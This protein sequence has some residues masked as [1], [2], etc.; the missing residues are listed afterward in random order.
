MAM[1]A[2][3]GSWIPASGARPARFA[4]WGEV[5]AGGAR[6]RARR[7]LMPAPQPHPFAA[8]PAQLQA[9]L[10]SLETPLDAVPETVH[11]LA[12][13]PSADGRPLPSPDLAP[14]VAASDDVAALVTWAVPALAPGPLH[15]AEVLLALPEEESSPSLAVGEDLRFW[16]AAARFALSLLARQRLLP[17]IQQAD[18]VYLARWHPAFDAPSDAQHWRALVRSMPPACGALARDVDTPL[19]RP[20]DLLDSFLETVMDDLARRARP[21]LLPAGP[22]RR[23]GRS[24]LAEAWLEALGGRPEVRAGPAELASFLR[25][26]RTWAEP[27]EAEGTA[28]FRV[29]FRLDP[30]AAEVAPEPAGPEAVRLNER[31]AVPRPDAREWTLH[32][33]LQATD[34]P[35]LLVPA[36]QVWQQRDETARFLDRRFD[37]PQERVLAALGKAARL[38]PPIEASLRSPG[39]EAALL[40]VEE[41][42]ELI[43]ERAALLQASGF[44]VL[45]PALAARL[46]VRVRLG[47]RSASSVQSG[48]AA[49]GLETLVDYDWE[50]ALGDQTLS[51]EEFETLARLKEPLVQ[52]RGQWVELRPEQMAQALAFFQGQTSGQMPLDE[53]LRLALAPTGTGGLPID[54]VASEGWMKELLRELRD[55]GPRS[56]LSEPPGFIGELRGYQKAGV[57]WLAALRRYGLGACLADDMGLGKTVQLIA[58]LL[59][60]R[61]ARGE[62]ASVLLVCPTSVVGNWQHEL[63]RFAPSLRVLAHH[64]AGR[65]RKELAAEVARHDVVISTYALLHRDEAELASLT[66]DAVVLDEA[67]N[68]KNAGTR[69]A[70]AARRLP[71]GWRVALTGTPVENRLSDLWSIFQF[72]NPGYLGS[73]EEFRRVFARPIERLRD[74][75][76]AGRLQALVSPFLLRRLKTDRS[77]IADLPEKQELKVFCT[78]TREQATL[79]EAVLRDALR[80]IDEAAGIQRRG[81]VLAMLTRLKQVCNHPALF[82]HDGSE[83]P[84]RSGKLDRL[85]EML[86]EVV[87]EGDRALVFTQYAQM[88]RLLKDYLERALGRQALFLHGGTPAAE[89]DRMVTR[90]QGDARAPHV[91]ILSLKAGGTGLNLTRANHVFHFDRW[92]NPAVENQA[93]DRAFRIGQRRDVLVHKFICL[94]TFEE[95]LDGLIERKLALAEAIVGTGETWITELSSAQLRDLFTLRR[96]ALAGG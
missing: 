43:R 95:A 92:W 96:E 26:Y 61:A 91:F 12:Q 18:G 68:I 42:H 52:V 94:G 89:R 2:L 5:S 55:S 77:V 79:Y 86:E 48:P 54:Q 74:A 51:R 64:G 80:E 60:G 3:H 44:G 15:A 34:D 87:A 30:P 63:R 88:G 46:G 27:P 59:Q 16:A 76:A 58:L 69:A 32:Y 1:L 90:F 19:S 31:V 25:E 50:L 6:P 13:L 71:A 84:A 65:T 56:T 10:A 37:R 66:W 70:Q 29:C 67:Q 14:E 24:S 73:P 78:L 33:L 62:A 17:A 23:A 45:V 82:L 38:F 83:L 57:G 20:Q 22:R 9:F 28:A 41:A 35:S 39:P 72:L 53:A 36:A 49:F 21:A 47:G 85:G 8:S 93:T 7:R 81:L 11:V 4:L 40:T 75:A